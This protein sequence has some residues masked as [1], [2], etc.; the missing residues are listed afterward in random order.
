MRTKRAR[1]PTPP[2]GATTKTVGK[3]GGVADG[4][5]DWEAGLSSD[6]GK[7]GVDDEGGG[8]DDSSSDSDVFEFEG[9]GEDE[10]EEEEGLEGLS[11][12]ERLERRKERSHALREAALRE[13]L[14]KRSEAD[15]RSPV[16]VVLGHVDTGKTKLL[17]C[18]RRTNVQDGTPPR[19]PPL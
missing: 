19:P 7:L 5:L 13:A 11:K 1:T 8:G 9:G 2:R 12:E 10:D 18:I 3:G 17:D 16:C 14:A 6:V 4:G 15:L